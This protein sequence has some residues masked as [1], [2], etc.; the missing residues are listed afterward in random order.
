MT[1]REIKTA[2]RSIL[3]EDNTREAVEQFW[4]DTDLDEYINEAVDELCRRCYLITD[5][6]YSLDLEENQRHYRLTSVIVRVLAV[7][8]S[9]KQPLPQ[10][11][12]LWLD[13]HLPN[14][15]NATGEPQHFVLDY[16][17]GYL[18]FDRAPTIA[19]T[20]RLTVNRLPLVQMTSDDDVPEIPSAYHRKTYHWILYRAYGKEGLTARMAAKAKDYYLKFEKDIEEIKRQELRFNPR[21]I[22]YAT[23]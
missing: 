22:G 4:L 15:E 6:L 23:E 17:K 16:L 10:K 20:F 2:I 19:N 12:V 13:R 21:D 7:K 5:S 18:T 3:A 9:G 11:T 14:W 1:R 8:P